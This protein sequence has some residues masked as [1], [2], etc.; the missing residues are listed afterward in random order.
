M[1]STVVSPDLGT[2]TRRRLLPPTDWY[3]AVLGGRKRQ[4]RKCRY[5]PAFCARLLALWS[6]IASV[7][8]RRLDPNSPVGRYTV[9]IDLVLAFVIQY[10]LVRVDCRRL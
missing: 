2:F 5:A 3:L 8:I 7:R 9:C 10:D 4:F 1:L 6:A